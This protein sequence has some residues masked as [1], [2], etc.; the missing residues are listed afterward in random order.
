MTALLFDIKSDPV[1]EISGLSYLPG[2]ITAA[3][4]QA[5]ITQIDQKPWLNELKRRVQHYGYRYDYKARA[6]TEDSYL[7]PLPEWLQSLASR[8]VEES[9]FEKTPDQVIVNEYLPGQGIAAHT[10][11]IPCFGAT[12]ASLSLGS[13]CVMQFSQN[14]DKEGLFLEERSLLTLSESARYHWKHAIPARKTDSVD[15]FKVERKR[16]VSLTFRTMIL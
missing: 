11:C 15:S 10:D 13:G 8:L 5:L 1:P 14:N 9:I 2:F 6:V 4:E 3:E 16:R 7:G 12:I